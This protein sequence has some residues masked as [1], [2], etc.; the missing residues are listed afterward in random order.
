[1]AFIWRAAPLTPF[2][3]PAF[4]LTRSLYLKEFYV[5]DA[6]R[7]QGVG[8]RLMQGVFDEAGKRGCGR[9]E[10]TP[11]ANNADAQ[12]F[13]DAL[14]VLPRSPRSSTGW[15]TAAPARRSPANPA[16]AGTVLFDVVRK[17][18]ERAIAGSP[19]V[20]P[21]PTLESQPRFSQH[22]AGARSEDQPPGS[23]D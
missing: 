21:R 11:D 7:R 2:L 20:S 14:G 22:R 5:A 8:K 16:G 18:T 12:A 13:Y 1:M 4:G 19:C 15:K 6:Y 17:L 23:I 3:W 9:V 10:W